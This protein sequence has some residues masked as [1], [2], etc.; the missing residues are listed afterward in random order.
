[1]S[2]AD[3]RKDTIM[4]SKKYPRTIS[5]V[6]HRKCMKTTKKQLVAHLS[7]HTYKVD[8]HKELFLVNVIICQILDTGKTAAQNS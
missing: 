3:H 6:N 2:R 7:S 8:R 4:P 1:M 5:Q